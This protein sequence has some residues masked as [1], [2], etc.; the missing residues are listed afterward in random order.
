MSQKHT[1]ETLK[2]RVDQLEEAVQKHR[3]NETVLRQHLDSLLQHGSLPIVTVNSDHAIT[4]CN[5]YFSDLFEFEEREVLGK[6][7]DDLIAGD[8]HLKEATAYTQNTLKGKAVHGVGRRYTKG[9]KAIDVEF[10][11]VPVIIDGE[12]TGAYG[13]YQDVSEQKKAQKA[14]QNEKDKFQILVERAP[15]GISLI[16][17]DGRY[18]YINP[19]FTD[20]FGYTLED[21]PT[22]R[23]WFKKAYPDRMY[24]NQVVSA[25]IKDKE[26]AGIGESRPRQW[27]VTCK[28][29]SEKIV[30]FGSVTMENGDQLVM[31]RDIT[32]AKQLEAQLYKAQKM[33]SL[34]ALAGGLAHNFNNVLMAIQGRASLLL[35][36]KDSSHPDFDHLKG[37]EEYVQS[38]AELTGDLLGFAR[39]GK[40]EVKPTDLNQLL[41]HENRLFGQTKKEITIHEKF[42][43]DL[44]SVEVDRGQIQQALMNLYVNAW[45]AMP[46]GGTL[47]IRT[48]NVIL[49]PE[50]VDPFEVSPGRYV[51]LSVTDTGAGMDAA[52]REK[53]FDPFFT[54]RK[55]GKGTGLGLASVY[56]IIKNHGGFIT[57]DSERGKGA[58]F[59][60]YLPAAEAAAIA[61]EDHSG[62]VV[63]GQGTILLVDD[64]EMIIAVGQAMLR[65]LGYHILVARNGTEA[66]DMV[67]N[68]HRANSEADSPH[69]PQ[70][71]PPVPDLIILDMIM[72][73]MGGGETCEQLK[74]IDP[75]I[76]VLLAS[77]YSLNG[78]AQKILDRYCDGFI[79]KPFDIKTLSQKIRELL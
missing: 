8:E 59:Y 5:T 20:I 38:A 50:H 47:Y 48:E 67:N 14:L 30:H 13:I 40:Y 11:A 43:E 12:V 72:P 35:M 73:G 74:Q 28:D 33:E 63:A 44:W 68:A 64:E 1:Y 25:W 66:L 75:D 70:S 56:G 36:D 15:F 19:K 57:V 60:M 53:I 34:G 31:Y 49:N 41:A 79:Q 58:T 24:R 3:R 4:A 76:K 27:T 23:E 32:E 7:L 46:G 62:E 52:T 54:T 21:I 51:K 37:I 42:A 26:S 16:Q 22:G 45:Q 39:G 2:Q 65:K 61:S 29:G 18:T 9:G 6:N 17:A 71:L 77:G 69:G 55:M 78:Q 10:T